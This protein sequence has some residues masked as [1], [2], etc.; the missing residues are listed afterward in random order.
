MA[1]LAKVA[2]VSLDWLAFGVGQG[3]GSAT[4]TSAAQCK[5]DEALMSEIYLKIHS[6]VQH[7]SYTL[8]PEQHI[9]FTCN[10]YNKVMSKPDDREE[11][12]T[13]AMVLLV[14]MLKGLKPQEASPE[15]VGDQRQA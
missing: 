7:H 6:L 15:T 1:K 13:D 3:A 11:L 5:A 9:E 2:N 4:A 12:I 10:V 8:S 14:T